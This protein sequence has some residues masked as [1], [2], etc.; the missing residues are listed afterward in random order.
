MKIIKLLIILTAFLIM[1]SS[2]LTLFST[3]DKTPV[4]VNVAA[5]ACLVA[6]VTLQ[7]FQRNKQKEQ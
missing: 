6:V 4:Y 1:I 2:A 3:P 5:M 7:N